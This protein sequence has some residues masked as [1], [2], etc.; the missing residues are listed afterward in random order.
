MFVCEKNKCGAAVLHANETDARY[1][2][3]EGYPHLL[4]EEVT[5][6]ARD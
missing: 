4:Y 3:R 1:W 6:L 5:R 2:D